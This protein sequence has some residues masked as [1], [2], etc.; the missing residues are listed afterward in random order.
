M[1]K[2]TF[3][4]REVIVTPEDAAA[5]VLEHPEVWLGRYAAC[6][7]PSHNYDPAADECVFTPAICTIIRKLDQLFPGDKRRRAI[8]L[9]REVRGPM[10]WVILANMPLDDLMELSEAL[11]RHSDRQLMKLIT[12][13]EGTDYVRTTKC[14][15]ATGAATS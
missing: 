15:S 10:S 9:F 14:G 5:V 11:R 4:N 2:L 12:D 7:Q 3:Q 13:M 8:E 6:D 1:I